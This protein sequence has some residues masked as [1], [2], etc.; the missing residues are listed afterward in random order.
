MV[1]CEYLGLPHSLE[2]AGEVLQLKRQK[3]EE[4]KDLVR[5]FCRPEI[6]VFRFASAG[7][8]KGLRVLPG[9]E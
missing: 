2:K 7:E 9:D 1:W 6:T 3:R 8:M 4:G 5:F